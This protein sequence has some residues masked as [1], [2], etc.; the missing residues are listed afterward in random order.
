MATKQT[1]GS[2]QELLAGSQTPVLVDFYAAWCGPCQIM[3]G[4]LE[5]VNTQLKGKIKVIKIDTERYPTLA[6]RHKIE[7]FPT[8]ILFKQGQPVDRIQGV[9]TAE[10]MVQRL[11]R[12]IR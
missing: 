2:F 6:S 3:A 7:A 1:F 8:L 12:F 4:V 5:Q 9:Q 11:T 10:Y